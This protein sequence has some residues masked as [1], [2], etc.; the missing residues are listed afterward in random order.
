MMNGST[1]LLVLFT[2]IVTQIVVSLPLLSPD[3]QVTL[4]ANTVAP[5]SAI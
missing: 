4:V 3:V 5:S 1:P 2:D